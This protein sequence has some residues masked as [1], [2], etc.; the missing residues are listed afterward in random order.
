MEMVTVIGS[1][2]MDLVVRT[3]RLPEAGETIPGAEFQLVPGGKGANQALASSRFGAETTMVGCVGQDAFG[4]VLLDS[5]SDSGVATKLVQLSED[6]PTGTATIIVEDN[7]EN[8]I[9][10]VAGANGLV[11]QAYINEVWED[12]SDSSIILLQHEIPLDTISMIIEKAD[13]EGISVFL[14]PAPFY[15][16]SDDI[17]SK[18]DVI[19]LNETEGTS[20]SGVPISDQETAVQA[21]EKLLQK[22][23][24][25]VIVTLG[26]QGS[27]LVNQNDQIFQPAFKVKSVDTTAAGDTFVGVYAAS[28]LDGKSKSEAL[29]FATA[30]AGLTVTRKGAQ[31]SIPHHE[32]VMAFINNNQ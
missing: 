32:E 25:T 1:L 2:N 20:L 6:T 7:G 24:G 26:K 5:L 30:A 13:A 3:D 12:I 31:P 18:L 8:R 27:V 10:V 15:P 11:S 21:A 14:N 19:I 22:G 16:I 17:L 28:I 29:L 23:V 4:P 9:I